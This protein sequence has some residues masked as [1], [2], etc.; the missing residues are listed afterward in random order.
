MDNKWTSIILSD[1]LVLDFPS[2]RSS[3]INNNNLSYNLTINCGAS[4]KTNSSIE[5]N[6]L[7]TAQNK[8][9]LFL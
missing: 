8:Q 1:F 4:A 2:L 3:C 9:P 7:V 6:K 5:L